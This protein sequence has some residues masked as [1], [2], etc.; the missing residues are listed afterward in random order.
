MSLNEVEKARI[1]ALAERGAEPESGFEKHFLWAIDDTARP[2]SPR[3]EQWVAYFEQWYCDRVNSLVGDVLDEAAEESLM[4]LGAWGDESRPGG[5]RRRPMRR[6]AGTGAP[7]RSQAMTR[8][9]TPLR[10]AMRRA[11]S[12]SRRAK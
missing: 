1:I 12:R 5:L 9:G 10:R 6:S 7:I 2:C 11:P 8:R 3:E 4:H